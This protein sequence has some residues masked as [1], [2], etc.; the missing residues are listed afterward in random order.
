MKEPVLYNLQETCVDTAVEIFLSSAFSLMDDLVF[1][2]YTTRSISLVT[3][4]LAGA[5][6]EQVY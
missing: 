4:A 5:K 2:L 3:G 6:I 1:A